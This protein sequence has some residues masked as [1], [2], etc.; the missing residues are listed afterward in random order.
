MIW[1]LLRTPS[2]SRRVFIAIIVGQLIFTLALG[3]TVAS[4][5]VVLIAKQRE[6]ALVHV[7]ATIAAG[8]MPMIADQ[9]APQVRAQLASIVEAVDVDYVEAICVSDAS[10]ARVACQGDWEGELR[11]PRED[12]S[13]WSLLTED[14]VVVQPVEVDGLPVASVRVRFAPPGV[15]ALT[16]PGIATAVGLLCSILISL[17]WAAWRLVRDLTEPLDELGEYAS[18]IAEGDFDSAPPTRY[19][20]E[21]AQLQGN[22][23]T[24][25]AQL[26]ERSE[27][28]ESSFAELSAAYASLEMANEQIERLS[29]VKSNFVAVAA[30]ELK[31]PLATIRIYSELLEAGEMGELSADATEAVEAISGATH[32]LVSIVSDLMDAALLERGVMPIE[33]ADFAVDTLL[34]GAVKDSAHLAA[35][36]DIQVVIAGELPRLTLHGDPLR[37]RQVLDNLLSNA[38][39]YS[40]SNTTVHV[41]AVHSGDRLRIEVRDEGRG[42]PA[43][44]E[45]KLFALFGRLDF[46]DSR[47]T[48]GLGLGLAISSRIV[49]A[50]GGRLWYSDNHPEPGSTFVLQLPVNGPQDMVTDYIAVSTEEAAGA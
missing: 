49:A 24:M 15:G 37:L 30:H 5:S 6:D 14:Q 39:K 26:K 27:R 28:L 35:P 1:R 23:S 46:G 18:R 3:F 7:S 43:G 41:S 2:L 31:S 13:P 47:D 44:S 20:A 8:L 9:Q 50:H 29:A 25:A 17:P 4:F 48:A 12:P 38:I 45:Q 34:S 36:R 16:T 42:I 21:I 32:R 22:L 11:Q 33:F 40:P 10:G 19:H